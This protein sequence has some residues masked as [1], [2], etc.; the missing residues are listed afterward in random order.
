[1]KK[2]LVLFTLCISMF[3]N[4]QVPKP[5][6]N[7]Y[8][9]D[10]TGSLSVEQ[11]KQL[12]LQIQQLETNSGVQFAIVLVNDLP[13]NMEIDDYAREIGRTWH[14]GNAKNGIVY[15]AVLNAHKQRLEVARELEGTL[16]DITCKDITDGIKPFFRSKDY[17]GGCSYLVQQIQSKIKPVAAEQKALLKK[18]KEEENDYSLLIALACISIMIIFFIV[19]LV[20]R[21]KHY[22]DQEKA[23]DQLHK[24]PLNT[25]TNS[26]MNKKPSK[27]KRKKKFGVNG[28]NFHPSGSNNTVHTHAHPTGTN[29]KAPTTHH[30]DSEQ[31]RPTRS[32]GLSSLEA[33]ALGAVVGYELGKHN[34]DDNNS[35]SNNSSGSS[36]DD[37]SSFG[38]WGSSSDDSS[39]SNSDSSFS[40]DSGSGFDGG[41][42]SNDW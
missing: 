2:L 32:S 33:G 42:S 39:S 31:Q 10:A 22:K 6:P 25:L 20:K 29:P 17:F 41:G 14:V 13:A 37:S 7:T 28:T 40:S 5:Q 34:N 27:L 24:D 11:I 12:N 3:V 21:S 8:V 19:W 38:N 16:P 30:T 36:S 9:N 18:P 26:N 4:A 15:V 23:L 35:S 1:M